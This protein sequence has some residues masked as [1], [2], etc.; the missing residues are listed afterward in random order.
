[1]LPH[2]APDRALALSRPGEHCTAL[3]CCPRA[4]LAL[5][6]ADAEEGLQGARGHRR[7][8]PFLRAHQHRRRRRRHRRRRA[9]LPHRVQAQ[10]TGLHAC[11]LPLALAGTT[12]RTPPFAAWRGRA[13]HQGA[14]RQDPRRRL[15]RPSRVGRDRRE[16]RGRRRCR[17]RKGAYRAAGHRCCR[18]GGQVATYDERVAPRPRANALLLSRQLGARPFLRRAV[19]D[20]AH[21]PQ[22]QGAGG[23]ARHH[24][25]YQGGAVDAAA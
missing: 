12:C 25:L 16:E 14:Q 9:T 13:R 24:R 20:G 18:L 19:R 23:R 10:A 2:R 17:A 3:A 7:G 15:R 1:M 5:G 6:G 21:T 11:H 4:P 8:A 22:P